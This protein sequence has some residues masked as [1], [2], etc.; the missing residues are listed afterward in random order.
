MGA[1][2][3]AGGYYS[4]LFAAGGTRTRRVRG[5]NGHPS[6][7]WGLAV[8]AGMRINFPMIGPGDYFQA[9]VNYTEGATGTPATPTRPG[10]AGVCICSVGHAATA[11]AT[12]GRVCDATCSGR[13]F[14]GDGSR[15]QSDHGLERSRR[16]EHFWTPSLRTSLVGAYTAISVQRHCQGPD[17]QRATTARCCAVAATPL[18]PVN[19]AVGACDFDWSY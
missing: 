12:D 19:C 5:S 7:K 16:Y 15:L 4:T 3:Q 9:Q 2:H 8:G 13:P 6:D 14:A 18:A 11:S 10:T 17:V 1:L